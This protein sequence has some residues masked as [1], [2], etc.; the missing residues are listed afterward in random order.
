MELEVRCNRNSRN[1]FKFRLCWQDLDARFTS[2]F[3]TYLIIT[4]QN[5]WNC[6]TQKETQ[7]YMHN[8]KSSNVSVEAGEHFVKQRSYHAHVLSFIFAPPLFSSVFCVAE[9]SVW[10]M[11]K[12]RIELGWNWLFW[13]DGDKKEDLYGAVCGTLLSGPLPQAPYEVVHAN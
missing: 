9:I 3:E 5:V 12:I 6:L 4:I 1:L 11:L 2:P 7:T 13:G 10:F 8:T